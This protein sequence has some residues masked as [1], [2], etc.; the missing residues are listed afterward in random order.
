MFRDINTLGY[1]NLVINDK[2]NVDELSKR[3]SNYRNKGKILDGNAL[4]KK[5]IREQQ[6]SQGN[7]EL[8]YET[9]NNLKVSNTLSDEMVRS[10]LHRD[11]QR[12]NNWS[13][14]I[15]SKNDD[16]EK[17]FNHDLEVTQKKNI[18]WRKGY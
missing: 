1:H 9:L 7:K 6:F 10:Q 2:K 3:I 14:E 8:A 16:V 18:F 17:I 11:S 5:F 13:N 4:E 12:M 15:R